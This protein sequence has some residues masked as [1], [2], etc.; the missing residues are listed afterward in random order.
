MSKKIKTTLISAGAMIIA[1]IIGT[2]SFNFGKNKEQENIQN[3]IN[4]SVSI[5]NGENITINNVTDLVDE[6]LKLQA[7]FYELQQQVENLKSQIND[8]S[9]I[10][11]N[12]EDV[13]N[14]LSFNR[15]CE[16]YEKGS[17]AFYDI[18]TITCQGIE[19]GNCIYLNSLNYDNL[20][21]KYNLQNSYETLKFSL[22]KIDNSGN[23]TCVINFY[24]DGVQIYTI[25]QSADSD[26]IEYVIPLNYGKIFEIEYSTDFT[27]YALINA[28]IS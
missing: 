20:V 28:I 26:I 18:R 21:A 6:Y 15:V 4:D 10:S 12:Y 5:I 22:G 11:Y 9:E 7:D 19:Y 25:N 27:G 24:I 1:A 23:S 17:N 2:V 8:S 14:E 3:Q 13:S 16:A